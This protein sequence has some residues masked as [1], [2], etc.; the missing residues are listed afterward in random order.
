MVVTATHPGPRWHG[1]LSLVFVGVI[2]TVVPLGYLALFFAWPVLSMFLVGFS[3]GVWAGVSDLF[4]RERTWRV[5]GQTLAQ[6]TTATSLS[7]VLGVLAAF[8]AYR[9]SFRGVALVRGLISVP[10]VLP[11]V[12]VAAAFI[13][14]LGP[15]SPLEW[16]GLDQSFTAIVIAL[17]FFNVSVVARIVGGSWQRCDTDT[18]QA[19]QVLG[20]TPTKAFFTITLPAL[21]PA[22]AS[23]ASL[24]LLF[25]A[26]AFGVVLVI[27]GRSF[28]NI[29]TEIYRL[30]VQYLD[31]RAAAVLSVVQ[32]LVIVV[33]LTAVARLRSRGERAALGRTARVITV[34]PK[35]THAPAIIV[36]ALTLLA[37]YVL[38]MLALVIT[39]FRSRTGEFTLQHYLHLVSPPAG[40]RLNAPVSEALLTSLV[41][42]A[43]ATLL[44]LM[45]GT[46]VAVIASRRPRNPLARR[47]ITAFDGVMMLPLG[48]SAVTLGFGLLLT[49]RNPLGLGFDLRASAALIPIA[50]SLIAI[51]LVVRTLLPQLRAIH[52]DQHN[53]AAMLGASPLR[54]ITTID[55]ASV[56]KS[57]GLAAGFAC[58]ASLGEFGATAFL[59]RPDVNTLPVIIAQLLSQQGADNYGMA[60]AA[61]VV[62][63]TLTATIMLIAESRAPQRAT[64]L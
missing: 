57:F 11:T 38:P 54:I 61:S 62:L 29:E 8:V 53:A 16:L 9:L 43:Q 41:F 5:I 64:P 7:V 58:A 20:A 51:P 39:S 44:A 2:A 13:A 34:R 10:F 55:L 60:L 37:L 21:A 22:I 26:T 33:T 14:L 56:R 31:L 49:M 28:A 23:A 27:G 24:V 30:T 4:G 42:A 18:E 1:R 32:F 47:A 12:V 25:C 19:A 15:A 52:P 45:M 35:R 40:S 46:L 63:A 6:A 3:D 59:V 50:Q 36:F 17:T 48:V